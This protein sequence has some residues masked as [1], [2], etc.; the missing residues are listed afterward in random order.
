M[1]KR[2]ITDSPAWRWLEANGEKLELPEGADPYVDDSTRDV[3][4][5]LPVSVFSQLKKRAEA[6][7]MTVTACVRDMIERAVRPPD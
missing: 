2:L 7:S 5:N 4:V 3:C 1:G 6:D